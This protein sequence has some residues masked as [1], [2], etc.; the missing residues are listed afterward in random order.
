[1]PFDGN[2]PTSAVRLIDAVLDVLGP[3]GERWIKKRLSNARGH[4]CILGALAYSRRKLRTPRGDLATDY[5]RQAIRELPG[6]PLWLTSV[7]CFN[8]YPDR[9]FTDVRDV[10]R[11]AR[12]LAAGSEGD[13]LSRREQQAAKS[14]EIPS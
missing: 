14:P 13:P 11:R 8:D 2:D 10:L 5:I 4:H 9:R 12:V 3:E 6:D 1:M 7:T